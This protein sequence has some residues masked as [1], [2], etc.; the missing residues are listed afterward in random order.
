MNFDCNNQFQ[1]QLGIRCA[2]NIALSPDITLMFL[3]NTFPLVTIEEINEYYEVLTNELRGS[4][5]NESNQSDI[6]PAKRMKMNPESPE[7]SEGD[8]K[9]LIEAVPPEMLNLILEKSSTKEQEALQKSSFV[10]SSF[11]SNNFQT[12]REVEVYVTNETI[13]MK[14][15]KQK[16]RVMNPSQIGIKR[17]FSAANT[18]EKIDS[19]ICS[20][21]SI[22][23]TLQTLKAIFTPKNVKITSLKIHYK[24]NKEFYERKVEFMTGF[25]TMLN[26]LNHHLHVENLT[27]V[28]DNS[29]RLL[30]VLDKLKPGALKTIDFTRTD[31]VPRGKFVMANIVTSEHWKHI[32]EFSGLKFE[33]DLRLDQ[34]IHIPVFIATI[35]QPSIE[36]ILN[37]KDK[38]IQTPPAKLSQFF[39]FDEL[40]GLFEALKPFTPA[41]TTDFTMLFDS[42]DELQKQL[43]IR[44]AFTSALPPHA[45]L[46]H[47]QNSFPSVTLREIEKM[48]ESLTT[49][50]GNNFENESNQTNVAS[51]HVSPALNS[52]S[53]ESCVEEWKI[54]FEAFPPELLYSILENSSTRE[55]ETLHKSSFFLSSFIYNNFITY[56]E[57]KFRLT[58]EAIYLT[59]E[60]Q[61]RRVMRQTGNGRKFSADD[62]IEKID[63]KT[64][65]S[66][67]ISKILEILKDILGPKTVKITTLIIYDETLSVSDQRSI[68]FMTGIQNILNELNHNLH[69]EELR[70][71]IDSADELLS[72]LNS[73]KPG[74]LKTV[75]LSWITG[76]RRLD[77]ANIVKSQHWK[78][79]FK[80]TAI[81]NTLDLHMDQIAH[82]PAF[83][84]SLVQQS[85]E[86]V[87]IYKNKLVQ[88]PPESLL[89]TI[90]MDNGEVLDVFKPF[91]DINLESL[92]PNKQKGS[93][94]CNDNRRI[95]LEVTEE[96]GYTLN[97]R[98]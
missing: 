39:I 96:Y 80:F 71:S 4:S 68:E 92:S 89:H 30:S 40:E 58:E 60:K 50:M 74:S 91:E 69:V 57:I 26:E 38:L 97:C 25:Q 41:T 31:E 79:I 59:V 43:C 24:E 11:I 75:Q 94:L 49:G 32:S 35:S 73:L 47:V 55:H 8:R 48:Y 46:L 93:I 64:H 20:P 5:Q 3:Q 13:H 23:E 6:S 85:S 98:L 70:I 54:S 88:S 78:H 72:I 51:S 1:K 56:R 14:V 15:E 17:K 62:T 81:G 2:F 36:E 90:H 86:N 53:P 22:P 67:T 29:D 10:L 61:E 12:Y 76:L 16:H 87:L 7:M 77:F 95:Q 44:S 21:A 28:I 33:L 65:D 34:I 63:S 45:A 66:A 83:V 18:S 82:I 9:C 19:A 27:I 42:N 52:K 37:Y 84:G